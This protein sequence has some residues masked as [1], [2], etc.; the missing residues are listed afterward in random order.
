M[1]FKKLNIIVAIVINIL[2]AVFF[3]LS[4]SGRIRYD[5][6]R[7]FMYP[8]LL[9]NIFTFALNWILDKDNDNKISN[10]KFLLFL[11]VTTILSFFAI[12]LLFINR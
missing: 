7:N 3:I 11:L 9:L 4:F 8:L 1:N 2:L 10:K 6:G 12:M 5:E